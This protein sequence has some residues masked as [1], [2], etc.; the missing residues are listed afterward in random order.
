M[1]LYIIENND[2]KILEGGRGGGKTIGITNEPILNS[3]MIFFSSSIGFECKL[4]YIRKIQRKKEKK[5]C[6]PADVCQRNWIN[7]QIQQ[8]L[9]YLY[10]V[11]S[12]YH[13]IVVPSIFYLTK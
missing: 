10:L 1:V 7:A 13:Y 3:T 11:V 8:S 6:Q 9:L 5:N 2:S 12:D 4:Y